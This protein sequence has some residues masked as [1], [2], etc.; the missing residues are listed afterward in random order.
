MRK[1]VLGGIGALLVIAAIAGGS[2][3]QP[4]AQLN[5]APV[6]QQSTAAA[7]APDKST[8]DPVVT[9]TAPSPA[10]AAQET[11]TL[12]TPAPAAS[13]PSSNCN[14]NYSPCIPNS[15]ADLDCADVGKRVTVIGTDVYRLDA[16]HDGV[17]CESY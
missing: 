6:S 8:T 7:N 4:T 9:T 11:T 10:P 12:S 1:K 5:V 3:H 15:A 13:S 17:G 16:D 14:P 2:N